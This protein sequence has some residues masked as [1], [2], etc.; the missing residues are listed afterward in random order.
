MAKDNVIYI[1]S[2]AVQ[3]ISGSCEKDD[4][5]KVKNYGEYALEEGAMINGVITD[6]QPILETLQEIAESGVKQ[7]R[8]VIDSGQILIKNMTV[9]ILQ[10][11]DILKIVKDELA[12]IENSPED[13]LYDYSVLQENFEDEEKKGGEILCCG[14]EHKLLGTY[15]DLFANAGIKIKSID[16]SV[17]ALHK[18]T[19]ELSDFENKSYIVSVIDA[20]NVSSYLYENNHYVFSNR[21]RL[22]SE[23]GTNAFVSELSSNISQ[24]IQFSKS[25]RSPYTIETAYFC[26]LNGSES[27][28]VNETIHAGLAINSEVFPNSK[29]VYIDNDTKQFE[30]NLHEYVYSVGSLIRK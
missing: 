6:E 22:F 13:I 17:N 3:V 15:I 9:P 14:I 2:H 25:K 19:Q 23:R 30:F 28:I 12:N 11:K 10:K 8:L 26:G 27:K 20:N 4:M 18:L 16:I 7:A 5:I 1:S 21:T 29:I 24:L